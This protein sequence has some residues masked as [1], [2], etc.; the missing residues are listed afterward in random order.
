M[1]VVLIVWSSVVVMCS[2]ICI[3]V[4]D[5]CGFGNGSHFVGLCVVGMV[6]IVCRCC[7][8]V[9]CAYL[10]VLVLLCFG[11]CFEISFRFLLSLMAIGFYWGW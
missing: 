7:C 11:N 1:G 10:F 5:V 3:C 9:R 6:L 8:V 4:G 2:P